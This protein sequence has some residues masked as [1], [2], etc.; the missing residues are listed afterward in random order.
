[1][2]PL[3]PRV[4]CVISAA[5]KEWIPTSQH[6]QDHAQP[7]P[8]RRRLV[9]FRSCRIGT[10]FFSLDY[11]AFNSS[12]SSAQR[13]GMMVNVVALLSAAR[14][15]RRPRVRT[16]PWTSWG[17]ATTRVFPLR[18]DGRSRCGLPCPAGPF[19]IMEDTPR[20]LVILDFDLRGKWQIQATT[21]EGASSV[22]RRTDVTTK[23][24]A[25]HWGA[26]KVETHL[27]YRDVVTIDS[28]WRPMYGTSTLIDREWF[29]RISR[30]VSRWFSDRPYLMSSLTNLNNDAPIAGNKSY[31]RASY[32]LG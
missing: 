1:L 22:S 28:R 16:V 7:S 29:I 5:E 19:W 17:P 4:R 32:R 14:S 8:S 18:A 11:D 24:V 20:E 21:T 6:R 3:K 12:P 26:G 25:Q 27:P 31:H 2:P 10:L 23:V 13:Y 30:K 9:P 15:D